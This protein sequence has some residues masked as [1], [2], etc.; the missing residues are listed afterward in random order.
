MSARWFMS[1]KFTAA[2]RSY[3]TF[4]HEAP[5][6]I[7]ALMKWE[8][9]LVG[10]KFHIVTD[11]EA[12]ETIK[13][14]NRDG[15][16]GCLIRWDEYLSRFKYEIMHVPGITNKVADC[17]SRYYENDRYDKIHESHHY[18][19]ANVRLDPNYE[20]LTDFRLQ[21]ILEPKP[22][23][24]LLARR[25]QDRNEDR[26]AEA[27]R[28]ADAI[29]PNL[30][31]G[32]QEHNLGNDITVGEALQNGPPLDKIVLGDGLFL[33]AVK[34]GYKNDPMFSKILEN[35]GHYLNFR[36]FEGI[37]HTKNR[38]GDECICIPRALYK[39]KYSLPEVTI[40][41]AH[42]TLGH[43]GSQK[44]SEY[45]HRW[46]WWPRMGHD[47][48]KFCL[49]CETCQMSKSS[50]QLKPGLLHSLPIPNCPWQSIG[51][52]FIGPFPVC[53]G[54]DYLWV[55]ICRLTN[56]SHLIPITV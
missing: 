47:I 53:Q 15:K 29:V 28:I 7:K 19:S 50:N 49:S 11:H 35:P 4:E 52:D 54:Y 45:A 2:Q 13:T 32:T 17:L 8:D 25:L 46:F 1:K 55:I 30:P 56:Q 31:Q 34:S 44:T 6:I 43:L 26:V 51:M 14:S 42:D 36:V 41:H 12:L 16:S 40:D 10:R 24:L 21:E 3:R 9:K 5:T 18:V 39:G 27:E 33:E 48:E 22:S 20:D 38:L 37:I 23:A